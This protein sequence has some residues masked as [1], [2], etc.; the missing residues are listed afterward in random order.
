[1]NRNSAEGL[2]RGAVHDLAGDPHQPPDLVTV[3]VSRGRRIRRRR[4]AGAV[5]AAF[6]AVA[7]IAA[8]YVLLRPDPEPPAYPIG[9]QPAATV[10]ADPVPTASPVPES[11]QWRNWEAAPLELPGGWIVVGATTTGS[12]VSNWAYDRARGRYVDTAK[13]FSS[14]WAA[15]RGRLAAVRQESR[16]DETGLLDIPTGR[17]RWIR[18]GDQILTPQWSTDGTR[19]LMTLMEKDTGTFSFGVLTVADDSFHRYPVRSDKY[20]CTDLCRFTW[21]PNGK[22]VVLPM[23]DPTAPRSESAPHLRRGLQL[24]S[25]L[26]GTPTRFVPVRGDVSGPSAWSPDGRMVVVKGQKSAQLVVVAKGTV[27]DEMPSADVTWISSDR[28]LYLDRVL[29]PGS[30]RDVVAVLVDPKGTEV[31]RA[32]LPGELA[33]TD[34]L[35]APR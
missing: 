9:G 12:P 13:D 24:F 19:L 7:A 25:A 21:G 6:V 31:D 8:P 16:P 34:I 1:M 15:P 27:V 10:T 23:T 5:A 30:S 14:V 18:T 33:G 22:E 29:N 26:D 28:L 17:V 35:V 32:V 20:M 11:T 3:A 2:L 4:Q